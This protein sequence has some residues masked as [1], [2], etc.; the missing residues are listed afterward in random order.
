[1]LFVL[2]K[3]VAAMV[4]ERQ[5]MTAQQFDKWANLPENIEKT[6]E[7]I[8]GEILEVVSNPKS[9]KLGMKIGRFIDAFV[10]EHD[11]GHVTGADG[12]Y[13][14]GEERFIPDVGYISYKRMPEL[15]SEDGY[16]PTAPDLA[17]EV[18]SPTDT[19]RNLTTK[20]ADYLAAG[21][22]VWLVD[23][24]EKQIDVC[25]P[26]EAVKNYKLEDTLDGGKV[27]EGFSLPLKKV[28]K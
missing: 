2:A 22:V 23:P 14:V 7:F 3:G 28:F 24:D 8:N 20:L 21:T 25:V 1:L 12:G 11:L 5:T 15:L 27:L 18:I 10:D 13:Q 26:N 17:V 9:S 6:Y 4:I 16:V 19:K